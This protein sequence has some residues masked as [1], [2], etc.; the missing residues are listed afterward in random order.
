[1][2]RPVLLGQEHHLDQQGLG[3]HLYLQVEEHH[4]VQQALVRL[5]EGQLVDRPDQAEGLLD[6]EVDLLAMVRQLGLLFQ[7][8]PILDQL[9]RDPGLQEQKLVMAL[10]VVRF[11]VVCLQE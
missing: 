6:P 4:L 10:L 2:L 3:P 1:V 8:V 5:P 11:M 7:A 9:V